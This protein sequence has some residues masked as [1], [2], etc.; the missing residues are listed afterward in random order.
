MLSKA[1]L[2]S[3]SRMSGS[4]S[5]ITPS[6]LSGSWRSFLYSYFYLFLYLIFTIISRNRCYY[7]SQWKTSASLTMVKPLTEWITKNWKI[8]KEMGMPDHLTC[9]L[10][11][12]YV[13]QEATVRTRH[14]TIDWFKIEKEV[15][16]SCI[17]SLCLFNFYAEYIMWNARL[18]ESQARIKIA[19]R[20]INNLR[21][22]DTTLNAESEEELNSLLIRV[23]D[24]REK[25]GL[26]LSTQRTKIIAS[27][28]ITLWQIE[29]EKVNTVIAFILLVSKITADGDCSHEIKLK[30]T[31]RDRMGREV[32]EG[33]RMGTTWRPMDDSYQ[34]M[35]KTT[36]IL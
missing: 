24:E 22:A 2:T 5:V 7:Y 29:G 21:Y 32:R 13:G 34:C 15:H 25:V 10:W 8:L 31:Q 9:F 33:F 20:N 18:D 1:H 16:Q 23:K 28:L 35:A 12:L 26:K 17:L 11:N 19:G 3:H 6:W 14:R 27:G 4:R 30:V 36:T